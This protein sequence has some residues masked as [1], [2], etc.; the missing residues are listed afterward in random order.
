[1]SPAQ[2]EEV[3]EVKEKWNKEGAP[4]ESQ[5]IDTHQLHKMSG[6]DIDCQ[7]P[8]NIKN[9]L[10]VS[11]NGTKERASRGFEFFAE[12]SKSEFYVDKGGEVEDH[13]DDGSGL[14]EVVLDD[15]GYTQLPSHDGI[16][17][18]GQQELVQI[19]FHVSY[20][21]FTH[22]SKPVPWGTITTKASEYLDASSIPEN[23][24]RDQ[25]KG[26]VTFIKAKPSHMRINLAKDSKNKQSLKKRSSDENYL[27]VVDAVKYLAILTDKSVPTAVEELEFP[28]WVTWSWNESYLPKAVHESQF[29]LTDSLMMLIN[30]PMVTTYSAGLVIL[31]LGLLLRDCKC[32]MEYEEDEALHDTPSYLASS[33]CDITCMV[34]VDRAVCD[35]KSRIMGLI[36][37]ASKAAL[38]G[39]MEGVDGED[40]QDKEEGGNFEEKDKEKDQEAEDQEDEKEDIGRKAKKGTKSQISSTKVKK[41]RTEDEPIRQSTRAKQPSKKMY[42]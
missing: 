8:Q 35:V 16:G 7:P 17:L 19:I 28:S 20:K 11:S 30:A 40:Q 31:G 1:M 6:P 36:E 10:S 38:G 32:I 39:H 14:S 27:E 5:A 23:F 34:K 25:K 2:K 24:V 41:V 21:V 37:V 3:S 29:I 42:M 15:E 22:S 13:E 9:K 12:W 26:L 18:K 33:F 4:E